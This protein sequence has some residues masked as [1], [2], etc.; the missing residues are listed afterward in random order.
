MTNK[1]YIFFYCGDT[2]ESSYYPIS[3]HKTIKG[4]YKSMMK[5]KIEGYE[6]WFYDRTT[7]GKYSYNK[8]FGKFEDWR[9]SER[10]ILE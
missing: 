2:M 10:E 8:M 3:I 6:A 5:H 1:V 4:A 9:V 7:F